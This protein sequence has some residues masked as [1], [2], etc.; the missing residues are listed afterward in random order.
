MS[1]ELIAII[2][3]RGGSKRIPRKNVRLFDGKP[4]IA[5]SIEVAK[6]SGLFKE[7]MVSTDDTE[8][9]SISKHYGAS[10]PFLRSVENSND[11]ATTSDVILEVLNEYKKREIH[12]DIACCLYPTAPFITKSQLIEAYD[13]MLT[14]NYDTVF[15]IVK[16]SFP[17]LRSLKLV[18]GKVFPNWPEHYN[19]RSQDLPL[20][21]HD[22]GQFYFFVT[23]TFLENKTFM[24]D[25]VG[26]VL[27]DEMFVQDID[28]EEDWKIAEMKFKLSNFKYTS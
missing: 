25:N 13:L 2:T 6:S 26:S 14:K 7:V 27:L 15:P 5:Y 19:S 23:R 12:F 24:N 8:I 11:Y 21:F 9:A 20:A 16:F 10:V 1:S 22:A 3:A 4:I 28:S 17:I 18:D